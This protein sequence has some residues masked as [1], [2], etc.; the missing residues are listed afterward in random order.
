MIETFIFSFSTA[1]KMVDQRLLTLLSMC[2]LRSGDAGLLS[3]VGLT[4]KSSSTPHLSSQ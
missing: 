4:A 3:L 2:K 1:E